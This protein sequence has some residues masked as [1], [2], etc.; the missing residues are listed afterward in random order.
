MNKRPELAELLERLVSPKEDPKKVSDLI[1]TWVES[2]RDEHLNTILEKT[3]LE[4]GSDKPGNRAVYG[5][6][7]S[8]L[9]ETQ[10][11]YI[12]IESY[13][14]VLKIDSLI[15][16]GKPKDSDVHGFIRALFALHIFLSVNKFRSSKSITLAFQ[17][18]VKLANRAE[19]GSEICVL[20][21]LRHLPITSADLLTPSLMHSITSSFKKTPVTN[22]AIA[23]FLTVKAL[24]SQHNI[25][26]D[27]ADRKLITNS[28]GEIKKLGAKIINN[29][30]FVKLF[31]VGDLYKSESLSDEWKWNTRYHCVYDAIFQLEN[32]ELSDFINSAAPLWT[33]SDRQSYVAV[34]ASFLKHGK[35]ANLLVR[36]EYI[37]EI[38]VETIRSK[39]QTNLWREQ[40]SRALLHRVK[41]GLSEYSTLFREIVT[42]FPD[43]FAKDRTLDGILSFAPAHSGIIQALALLF[44]A[45]PKNYLSSIVEFRKKILNH[46]VFFLRPSK[47][48]DVVV[49]DDIEYAFRL[50][51]STACFVKSP[52]FETDYAVDP[53][54]AEAAKLSIT[55]V[56]KF[57]NDTQAK[58]SWDDERIKLPVAAAKQIIELLQHDPH[59]FELRDHYE[60]DRDVFQNSVEILEKVATLRK[61]QR[62]H[63]NAKT[64]LEEA[65]LRVQLVEILVSIGLV[66]SVL[67]ISLWD[68]LLD[69][70]KLASTILS[71]YASS[72]NPK[73]KSKSK[74]VDDKEIVEQNLGSV[75]VETSL[76]LSTK[77]S[78]VLKSLCQ[79]LINWFSEFI[80]ADALQLLYDVLQVKENLEGQNELFDVHDDEEDDEDED[81]I[82]E[83]IDNTKRNDEAGESDDDDRDDD[84]NDDEDEDDDD[85]DDDD[86]Y[87]EFAAKLESVLG[88]KRK[89]EDGEDSG[90]DDEDMD[91]DQMLAL[92]S[93]IALMFKDRVQGHKDKKSI[94]K[95]K[96]ISKQAKENVIF[97]KLRALDLISTFVKSLAKQLKDSNGVSDRDGRGGL[98]LSALI[99]LT[100]LLRT[101]TSDAIKN[102][103]YNILQSEITRLR[104]VTSA[105]ESAYELLDEIFEEAAHTSS[106]LHTKSCVSSSLFVAKVIF[107][108]SDNED[109]P[110]VLAQLTGVYSNLM[111]Q[112]VV[113][114]KS[115]VSSSLFIDFIKW[116]GTERGKLKIE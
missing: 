73:I 14:K 63:K 18:L 36:N 90:S 27:V 70:N 47:N 56:M 13:R 96:V 34:V 51:L 50:L 101:T 58:L 72:T 84:V 112:W 41:T 89:R 33:K 93:K 53:T 38:I 60:I 114:P 62:K 81:E 74:V 99:P 11:E 75:L 16:K 91:D 37:Q 43:F 86:Q 111:T 55:V 115:T 30:S 39:K 69:V 17:D 94:T 7:L 113:N 77:K 64:D 49:S 79:N 100:R 15:L 88:V 52:G 57:L 1:I 78:S 9:L 98:I 46:L 67:G 87:A 44:K 5:E 76:A 107:D 109:R 40:I 31:S 35:N 45:P 12:K 8:K 116:V 6:V 68:E 2:S 28:V 19:W 103:I 108:S 24:S 29:G 20:V 22:N 61:S 97:A 102:K 110:S 25:N 71:E 104:F 106:T 3:V 80:N 26:L 48:K 23:V 10:Y 4:L 21:L 105:T 92:D 65:K 95:K 42:D 82:D 32:K 83:E 54:T 66:F 59:T 85:D